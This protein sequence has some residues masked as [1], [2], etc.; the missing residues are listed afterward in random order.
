MHMQ[1]AGKILREYI[2]H[3]EKLNQPVN[4]KAAARVLAEAA[5]DRGSADNVSCV[6]IRFA[7]YMQ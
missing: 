2:A 6:V 5:I 4:L 1:E 3:Q 7:P